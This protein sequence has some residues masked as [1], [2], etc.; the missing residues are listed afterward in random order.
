MRQHL[1]VL[2]TASALVLLTAC[3]L[4]APLGKDDEAR[5]A[6][7]LVLT[8][9]ETTQQAILIYGALPVCDETGVLKL[10]RDRALWIKIKA[11]D[12]A[13]VTAIVKAEPVLN[14][15]EVDAGQLA[16][17]WLAIAEVKTAVQEAQL[18]LKGQN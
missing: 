14:G 9:Y 2:F 13:A 12:K 10:C 17:A 16:A 15:T 5:Y 18:K 6:S 1:K 8:G 3:A 7:K 11:V 4:L